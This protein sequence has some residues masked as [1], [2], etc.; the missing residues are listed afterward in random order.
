MLIGTGESGALDIMMLSRLSGIP[1]KAPGNRSETQQGIMDG[2]PTLLVCLL[3]LVLVKLRQFSEIFAYRFLLALCTVS[4]FVSTLL[5]WYYLSCCNLVTS[6]GLFTG[7]V[8]PLF[9]SC[10]CFNPILFQAFSRIGRARSIPEA[11]RE[12]SA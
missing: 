4:L 6:G 3:L 12:K 9:Q 8:A 11:S 7:L 10:S 2:I 1:G 5:F